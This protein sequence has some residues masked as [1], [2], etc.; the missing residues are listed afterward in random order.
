LISVIIPTARRPQLLL[1]AISSALGQSLSD[2]EIVVVVD[3]PD[4]ETSRCLAQVTDPRFRY[5]Q[6]IRSLGSAEARNVGVK[7][8]QGEWIA[9]LDDDDEW[10]ENKL[11]LQLAAAGDVDD[12]AVVS[13]LSEVVTPLQRYFWPRQI[14]DNVS[15]LAE[16]LFDRRSW[17]RG[18]AMLQCSSLL[19]PRWLFLDLM[20]TPVHDD[21]DFLLR[22]VN[23]K[24]AKICTVD[25][26]LVVHYIED[27]RQ[28]LGANFDWKRSLAWA[29]ANRAMINP[30]AYAGFC[31]TIIAPQAAKAGDHTAFFFLLYRAFRYGRPRPVHVALY[32]AIWLIPMERR[33]KIRSVWLGSRQSQ[34]A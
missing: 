1:R 23:T 26:P 3:G 17:F 24:G 27:D 10:R 16:Y 8:A 20:F 21:W 18:E 9:F 30:R 29:D 22:A 6:N 11:E 32:L 4:A 33:Q 14:Y 34:S 15:P 31:L 5:V 28:S 12:C 7:A 2:L 13:C 19:I 25:K